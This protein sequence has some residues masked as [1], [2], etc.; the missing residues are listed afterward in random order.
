ML[1]AILLSLS[2]GVV[3]GFVLMV[4]LPVL[5]GG[6]VSKYYFRLAVTALRT[7]LLVF[8][9]SGP[10]LKS[11]R[12]NDK[13]GAYKTAWKGDRAE[14]EDPENMMRRLESK[15]FGIAIDYPDYRAIITPDVI[16]V[17][18]ILKTRKKEGE[19]KTSDGKLKPLARLPKGI[20][21]V[22]VSDA[23]TTAFGSANARAPKIIREFRKKSQS[24]FNRRNIV[25]SLM[26]VILFLVG[27]FTPAM[28]ARLTENVNTSG[29]GPTIPIDVVVGLL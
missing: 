19:L 13:T 23:R 22:N 2:L 6:L 12:Y 21:P 11:V 17:A 3:T 15:P 27:A 28:L 29:S 10:E 1:T 26:Y 14:Y 18:G 9:S 24:M 25:T 16:D 5:S 4:I 8:R 7:G 20:I